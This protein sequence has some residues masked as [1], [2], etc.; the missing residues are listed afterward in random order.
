MIFFSC[1]LVATPT[2]I[3]RLSTAFFCSVKIRPHF[4]N[5]IRVSSPRRVPPGAGAV[6]PAPS[7]ATDIYIIQWI[8]ICPWLS[9][10]RFSTSLTLTLNATSTSRASAACRPGH[11]YQSYIAGDSRKQDISIFSEISLS[12]FQHHRIVFKPAGC[13]FSENIIAK[14][15]R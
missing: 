4:L 1:R 8:N 11:N 7:D 5:F 10:A 14:T 13:K 6:R 2:F 9:S 3:R 12:V 15:C